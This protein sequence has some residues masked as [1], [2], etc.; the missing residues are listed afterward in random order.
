MHFCF[1]QTH[2]PPRFFYKTE[3]RSFS[4]PIS[5]FVFFCNCEKK[6]PK[7]QYIAA[8]SYTTGNGASSVNKG[9]CDFFFFSSLWSPFGTLKV[10]ANLCGALPE[11]FRVNLGD[12]KR[13]LK[14]IVLG[15]KIPAVPNCG[16]PHPGVA[17]R[18]NLSPLN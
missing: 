8:K 12:E 4:F 14:R 1:F 6:L 18:G 15:A 3:Q 7:N 5:N 13:S 11:N 9:N 2:K 17:A 10:T 16:N